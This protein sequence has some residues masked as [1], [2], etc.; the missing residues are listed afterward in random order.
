MYSTQ[1]GPDGPRAE[2]V[3]NIRTPDV[4]NQSGDL[5]ISTLKAVETADNA[6]ADLFSMVD[7]LADRLIGGVPILAENHE[8]QPPAPGALN[9]ILWRTTVHGRHVSALRDR[10]SSLLQVL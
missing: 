5:L 2:P 6:L 4:R 10:L 3:G 1:L 8:R 9:E 7:V